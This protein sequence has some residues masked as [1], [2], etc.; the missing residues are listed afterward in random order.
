M[1]GLLILL[2]CLLLGHFFHNVFTL[3]VPAAI[4]GM[5]IL[6]VSLLLVGKTP[7]SLQQTTRTL[8]PL[9]PLFLMP[10]STGIVTQGETIARHG[11]ALLV[12]LIVSLIPGILVCGWIMGKGYFHD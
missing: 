1:P 3:P 2:A 7:Q 6:L 4:I 8:S 9:L 10:V 12:I 11:P 5:L